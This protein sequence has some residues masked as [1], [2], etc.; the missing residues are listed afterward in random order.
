[1]SGGTPGFKPLYSQVRDNLV[2]RIA[3]GRWKAGEALP[4]EMQ[5]AASS[6]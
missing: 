5:I 4:S 2:Q 6:A 1:M 3:D